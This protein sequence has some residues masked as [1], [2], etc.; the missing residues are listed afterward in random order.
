MARVLIIGY[1]PLPR[2]GMPYLTGASLRTRQLLKPIQEAGHTVNLFTLPIHGTEGPDGDVPAMVP[3]SYEGLGFQRFTSHSGE[4]AIKMLREQAR[5]LAPDAILG[6]NTYPA[7]LGAMLE[8]PIPLWADMPGYWM[9]E[10]Q[11]LCWIHQDDSRMA[12]AWAI[13]RTILRRLDKFSS[14][15]RA[16]LYA[17]IGELA[18]V[19]RLNQ[20]T[21]E[22][23]FGH[24][25]PNACCRWSELKPD[26]RRAKSAEPPPPGRGEARPELR[27]PIVPAEAFIILWSGS[28]KVSSDVSLLVSVVNKLMERYG[29]VHF[30]ATGGRVEG[31]VARPYH[32]FEELVEESPHRDRY[33]LLGWVTS[34]RL[35][36]IYREV[37]MAIHADARNYETMFGGRNR[38]NTLAAE[39]VPVA[40]TIGTEISEWLNDGHA[41]MA[42]PLGD[43]EAMVGAIEPWIDQREGLRAY[44]QR[45]ESLAKT[46]FSYSETTR[47]LLDWLRAPKLAPDNR[48]KLEQMQEEPVEFS[49]IALNALEE[50]AILMSNY[51]VE[52]LSAAAAKIEEERSKKGF[53]F[54]FRRT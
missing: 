2:L 49:A 40:T 43:V 10:N 44:A 42:A 54:G 53:L 23:P 28:F 52:E 33:H 39:G 6:I 22:Y 29:N 32:L 30:V 11:G 47:R 20:Y 5:Q 12:E 16:Q 3:D 7:Y 25:V 21:F 4:F 14:V 9:A 41:V 48:L 1:G 37:D 27:G 15:T 45:A 17:V 50:Q 13:E 31:V 34:D 35:P 19:G 51:K 18:S 38:L 26:D 24:F 36:A 8:L 46:D